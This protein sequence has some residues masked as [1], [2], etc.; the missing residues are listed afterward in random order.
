V[1]VVVG[2]RVVEIVLVRG[3]VEIA[4]NSGLELA[5]RAVLRCG[6]GRRHVSGEG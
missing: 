4:G 6:G 1:I 5:L 2:I 3:S